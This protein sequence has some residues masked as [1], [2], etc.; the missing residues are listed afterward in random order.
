MRVIALVVLVVVSAASRVSNLNAQSEPQD[1]PRQS[2]V[3]WRG[4][5]IQSCKSFLVVE[6]QANV[7]VFSS[8]RARVRPG[9]SESRLTAF[10]HE[11]EWNLGL[12]RNVSDI[13]ALGG[14]AS[15][16]TRAES[17]PLTGL[18]V[19]ARRW[20]DE[21]TPQA[22]RGS[23]EVEAG[24]I[25]T[26]V[27]VGPDAGTVWGASVGGRANIGDYLAV[28]AR[29]DGVQAPGGTDSVGG[30]VEEA[31]QHGLYVG[32]GLG[33]TWAVLGSAAFGGLIL[34]LL[35]AGDFD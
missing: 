32:A 34:W 13:W 20:L 8:S 30:E 1:V 18:R 23:V 17:G 24:L 3:C 15:F 10:E 16:G 26:A 19:R 6:M 21:D 27:G 9:G 35:S 12:M 14:T 2:T 22:G 5:P 29:W 11:L 28:F 4:R 7:A 31:F 25:A 33:H